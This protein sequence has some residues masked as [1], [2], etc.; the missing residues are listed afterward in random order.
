MQRK[1]NHLV[2][3]LNCCLVYK[4]HSTITIL[5]TE[6]L[7]SA[8]GRGLNAPQSARLHLW[9]GSDRVWHNASSSILFL[10]LQNSCFHFKHKSPAIMTHWNRRKKNSHTRA[11][12]AMTSVCICKTWNSSVPFISMGTNWD[13][14][15]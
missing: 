2:N 3:K 7:P 4:L 13:T 9:Q 15:W 5:T 8:V 10:T 12:D 11:T 14:Q 6:L 1:N